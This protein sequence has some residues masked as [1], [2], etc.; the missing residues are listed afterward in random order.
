MR[1]RLHP[2]VVQSM[3]ELRKDKVKEGLPLCTERAWQRVS[4]AAR[5]HL[6]VYGSCVS[7][8][9]AAP[10]KSCILYHI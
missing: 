5:A 2:C 8:G 1:S 6:R 9:H 4:T 10:V 7:R 3:C